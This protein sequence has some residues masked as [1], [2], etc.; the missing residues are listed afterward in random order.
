MVASSGRAA[1]VAGKVE[2]FL[3]FRPEGSVGPVSE[4]ST[5]PAFGALERIGQGGPSDDDA[6]SLFSRPARKIMAPRA[7]EMV[8]CEAVRPGCRRYFYGRSAVVGGRLI[9]LYPKQ[10]RVPSSHMP[11]YPEDA[12][13]PNRAIYT[14][15]SRI[16]FI[17]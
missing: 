12:L 16:F 7:V 14:L 1:R 9:Y 10:K 13:A 2:K 3:N 15:F 6:C 8:W 11:W 17:P 5:E 4:A